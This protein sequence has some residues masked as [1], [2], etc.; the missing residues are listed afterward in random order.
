[1]YDRKTSYV[2]STV[3]NTWTCS[4][5]RE[6]DLLTA[7]GQLKYKSVIIDIAINLHLL[8]KF[9]KK[10]QI[11]EERIPHF[12]KISYLKQIL[13]DCL[14]ASVQS[15]SY[16]CFKNKMSREVYE[17]CRCVQLCNDSLWQ[18]FVSASKRMHEYIIKK[19]AFGQ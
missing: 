19:K 3:N 11:I 16:M 14:M 4:C 5:D 12:V 1:M 6:L 2:R 9:I 8:N 7:S 18:L 15:A 17:Y 13:Y 10:N